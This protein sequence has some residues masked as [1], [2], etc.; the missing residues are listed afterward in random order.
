MIFFKVAK[1]KFRLCL[2][3]LRLPGDEKTTISGQFLADRVFKGYGVIPFQVTFG[4]QN[5]RDYL[6]CEVIVIL[7]G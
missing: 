7:K 2:T 1:S 4:G 3:I 5:I 6:L